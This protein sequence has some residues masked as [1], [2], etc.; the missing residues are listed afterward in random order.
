M[1][2]EQAFE[3][4][5]SIL[6]KA[7]HLAWKDSRTSNTADSTSVEQHINHIREASNNTWDPTFAESYI[8]QLEK[9]VNYRAHLTSFGFK[10]HG[11]IML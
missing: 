3:R 6:Q 8:D 1:Q 2:Y 5:N 10:N 7:R 11:N 4:I 9:R